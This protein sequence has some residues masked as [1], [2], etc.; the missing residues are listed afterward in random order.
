MLSLRANLGLNKPSKESLE[1]PDLL[2]CSPSIIK[3]AAECV[4]VW[5]LNKNLIEAKP[6]GSWQWQINLSFAV[7]FAQHTLRQ[8]HWNKAE[9]YKKHCFGYIKGLSMSTVIQITLG[10]RRA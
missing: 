6:C 9:Q 2:H 5:G 4:K 8:C 10:E 7:E 3:Y 1:C